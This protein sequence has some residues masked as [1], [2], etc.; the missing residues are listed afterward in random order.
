[1]S[2]PGY[3]GSRWAW[4]E[5][6]TQGI[7]DPLERFSRRT[8]R[9]SLRSRASILAPHKGLWRLAGLVAR[10]L[11]PACSTCFTN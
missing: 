2:V 4:P 9:I 10:H 11:T 3:G 7:L 1:M 5:E 6:G 8:S